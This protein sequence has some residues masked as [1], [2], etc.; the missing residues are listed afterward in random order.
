[1]LLAIAALLLLVP[2]FKR[3]NAL[4]LQVLDSEA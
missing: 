3:F 4:R 1:V 2:L